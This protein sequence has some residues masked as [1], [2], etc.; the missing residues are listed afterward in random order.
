L[1]PELPSKLE[2]VINKALEKDRK[3]R[4]QSAA[5]LRTD[6]ARLKRDTDSGRSV[7]GMP[8]A[9]APSRPWWRARAARAIAAVLV[10]AV[11]AGA[12][13]S[14]K[15]R[16]PAV[17]T[18]L[19]ILIR[20]VASFSGIP[21]PLRAPVLSD[22]EKEI[23]KLVAQGYR[24]KEISEKLFL[25]ETTVANHLHKIFGK[26]GV[27]HRRELALHAIHHGVNQRGPGL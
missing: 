7:V 14:G 18:S 17:S 6:L 8:T 27:S 5:D 4:Y 25:S 26:L 20:A 9:E 13:P 12:L 1:N 3:L 24:N 10:V 19:L 23:V 21:I 2:E 15:K 22:R 11:L 16:Q